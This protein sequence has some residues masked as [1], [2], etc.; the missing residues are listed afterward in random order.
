MVSSHVYDLVALALGAD[1]DVA[2]NARAGGL[3]AARL[4]EAKAYVLAHLRRPGLSLAEI[5]KLQGV[6][7]RYLRMLFEREGV[8]FSQFVRDRRLE[9]AHRMLSSDR[10]A[11]RSIS[12]IA[13]DAG[14]GDLSHFNHA[15]RARY[16]ATPSDIRAQ[17]WSRPGAVNWS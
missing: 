17:R 1:R 4:N 7:P 11:D 3:A 5:A 10:F 13:Y 9:L 12:L 6:T 15:F 14:F 8:T 2:E 16:G